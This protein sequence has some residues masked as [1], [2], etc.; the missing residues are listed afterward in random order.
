MQEI[1]TFQGKLHDGVKS[2]A[3][4]PNGKLLAAIDISAV[5]QIALYN[6][7]S[8]VCLA[9]TQGDMAQI[10]DIQFKNDEILTTSGVRHLKFWTYK[11]ELLSKQAEWGA[12][13]DR[14]LT[15]IAFNKDHTLTG[16]TKGNLLVW[17]GE[18]FG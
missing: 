1:Q 18:D 5:H 13:D 4:S 2:L 16:T 10:V 6:V 11:K 7:E 3:F 15:C 8:G 9:L 14:N 17:N 12:S